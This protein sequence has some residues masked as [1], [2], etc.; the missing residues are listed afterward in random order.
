M[1]EP[2]DAAHDGDEFAIIERFF[3]PLATTPHARGLRDDAALLDDLVVTVDTIVE[4]VHFLPTDPIET[5]ARKALRVNLSDLAAKGAAPAYY[6]LA[7]QW[8]DQRPV[9]EIAAFAAGLAKDQAQ[10]AVALLGGDTTATPGPLAVTITAFGRPLGAHTPARGDAQVGDDVWVSGVIGAGLLGL[11]AALGRAPAHVSPAE[12][13]VLVEHYRLP[14]PRVDLAT[15]IAEHAHASMDV[16]DGLIA[17]AVKIAAAS[18]L[19]LTID[20]ADVPTPAIAQ[21]WY[22]QAGVDRFALARGGDDYQILFTAPIGARGALASV[23][24]RI[25][26]VEAGQGLSLRL[27][28]VHVAHAGGGHVH[29]LG[30]NPR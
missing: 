11:E 10:F 2:E 19:A 3:A 18:G 25:G 4:G 16:S 22:G 12:C 21:S 24:T 1:A 15:V 26:A 17:D 20:L 9:Q 8:P 30:C 23:A 28:G 14:K 6:L 13:A 7:L 27:G 29:R 5:V